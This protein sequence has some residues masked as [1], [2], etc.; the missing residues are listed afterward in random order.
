MISTISLLSHE[1]IYFFVRLNVASWLNFRPTKFFEGFLGKD[2]PGQLDALAEFPMIS[3]CMER[4]QENRKYPLNLVKQTE[5]LMGKNSIKDRKAGGRLSHLVLKAILNQ[6]STFTVNKS[7]TSI[8]QFQKAIG[9]LSRIA[10]SFYPL[11]SQALWSQPKGNESNSFTSRRDEISS[12][13]Q[14]TLTVSSFWFIQCF[15]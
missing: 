10:I 11:P 6:V 7:V 12:V 8:A 3:F 2:L 13:I 5:C 15:E 14:L 4:K 9:E 1:S